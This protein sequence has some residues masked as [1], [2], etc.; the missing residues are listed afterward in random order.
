M[1][2]EMERLVKRRDLVPT[3]SGPVGYAGSG[4]QGRSAP[5]VQGA[6]SGGYLGRCVIEVPGHAPA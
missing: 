5:C 6:D 4:G 2:S 1:V 3:R